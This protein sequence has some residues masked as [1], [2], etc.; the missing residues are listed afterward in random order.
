MDTNITLKPTKPRIRPHRKIGTI[1][2]CRCATFVAIGLD[3]AEAYRNWQDPHYRHELPLRMRMTDIA[4]EITQ[5][6]P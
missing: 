1:W 6:N 4:K 3:G 5:G 2:S